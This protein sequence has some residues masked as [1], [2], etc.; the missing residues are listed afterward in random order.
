M[1]MIELNNL[2]RLSNWPIS[3][4]HASFWCLFL[5]TRCVIHHSNIEDYGSIKACI[6]YVGSS[7]FN[8]LSWT[9]ILELNMVGFA[10]KN[11]H[12]KD[13]MCDNEIE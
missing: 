7:V 2:L 5:T 12:R 3:L 9:L 8:L 1:L 11:E 6:V 4:S 13:I 10:L